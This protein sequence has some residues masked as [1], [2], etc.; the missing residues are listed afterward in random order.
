MEQSRPDSKTSILPASFLAQ[1]RMV[2][3]RSKAARLRH[4]PH[5]AIELG[6]DVPAQQFT[7][8]QEHM[9][10]REQ[11]DFGVADPSDQMVG[12]QL[13]RVGEAGGGQHLGQG[14]QGVAVEVK[15][16][17]GLVRYH[18][19][20]LAQ[21][22][23]RGHAGG[24]AVGVAALTLDAADG[25][26]EATGGIGPIGTDGQYAGNIKGA[27]DL[28]AGTQ[29]DLVAQVQPHQGVVHEQQALAQ[30]HADVV[31]KFQRRGPGAAFLA[32]HHDEV[33]QHAALQHGLGDG[34]EFPWV[35]QAELEAYRFAAGQLA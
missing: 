18:Q 32:I 11:A 29:L 25:K 5:A 1:S 13:C 33:W 2:C 20:T 31:G 6:L 7:R 21:R 23:L 27:D 16:P 30:R 4:A 14:M 34:H 9:Q 3:D 8:L 10:L 12:L 17:L 24:A 26:H 22:I 15:Y 35:A 19:C 28:A